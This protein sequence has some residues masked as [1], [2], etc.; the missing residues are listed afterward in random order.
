MLTLLNVDGQSSGNTRANDGS[1]LRA[2]WTQ[3]NQSWRSL[4]PTGRPHL[5]YKAI[6]VIMKIKYFWHRTGHQ[7]SFFK[8]QELGA[9]CERET[10]YPMW[11]QRGIMGIFGGVGKLNFLTR[12]LWGFNS[13]QKHVCETHTHTQMHTWAYCKHSHT[14][15]AHITPLPSHTHAHTLFVIHAHTEK[16]PMHWVSPVVSREKVIAAEAEL[17]STSRLFGW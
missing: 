2:I 8:Y 11:A 15:H 3:S 6:V 9:V 12:S 16:L 10:K 5:L 13:E 17:L 14:S 7:L 4:S 1:L